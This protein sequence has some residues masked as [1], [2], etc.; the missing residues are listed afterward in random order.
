M[1]YCM[2]VENIICIFVQIESPT[3]KVFITLTDTCKKLGRE[4]PFNRTVSKLY[5]F[6]LICYKLLMAFT[7]L[8]FRFKFFTC[9]YKGSKFASFQWWR[10]FG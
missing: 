1:N 2:V 10:P 3:I 5:P 9:I 4:K 8:L 6:D 7:E